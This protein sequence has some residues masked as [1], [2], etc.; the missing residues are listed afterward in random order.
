MQ[1]LAE[2]AGWKKADELVGLVMNLE[3]VSDM[4]EVLELTIP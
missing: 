4:K 3:Q 2:T 1:R